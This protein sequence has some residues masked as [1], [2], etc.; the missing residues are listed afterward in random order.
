M[1]INSNPEFKCTIKGNL[2][3]TTH[4]ELAPANNS[5]VELR[6]KVGNGAPGV[7]IGSN[8]GKIAFY[9]RYSYLK[10]FISTLGYFAALK[11]NLSSAIV[12]LGCILVSS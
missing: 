9:D 3:L 8:C 4:P 7:N 5:V 11:V 6:I 12:I 2:L 10:S 1:G